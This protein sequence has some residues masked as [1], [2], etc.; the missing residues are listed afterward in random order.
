MI[1]KWRP[2]KRRYVRFKIHS[3]HACNGPSIKFC[4]QS[5]NIIMSCSEIRQSWVLFNM[6]SSCLISDL[7]RGLT[8]TSFG[9]CFHFRSNCANRANGRFLFVLLNNGICFFIEICFYNVL[10]AGA[11][12]VNLLVSLVLDRIDFQF[13]VTSF[14]YKHQFSIFILKAHGVT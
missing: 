11:Q 5:L 2:P 10:S 9:T 1:S 8:F 13:S 6:P 7:F 3:F 4:V 12:R 14:S